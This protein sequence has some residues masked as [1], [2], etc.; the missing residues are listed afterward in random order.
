VTTLDRKLKEAITAVLKEERP[1]LAVD[2]MDGIVVHRSPLGP[3]YEITL[4]ATWVKFVDGKRVAI[5]EG[6]QKEYVLPGA[7]DS[8]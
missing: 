8:R 3:W 7:P 6:A 4:S 1:E 2:D 5:R